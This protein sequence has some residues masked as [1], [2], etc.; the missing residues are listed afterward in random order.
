MKLTQKDRILQYLRTGQSLTR[1]AA[2]DALGVL[3]AP[4]RVSELRR[5]G[6]SIITTMITVTNR[7]GEKVKIARWAI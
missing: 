2:W 4:A 1:L 7:F 6:H 5:D 3:E